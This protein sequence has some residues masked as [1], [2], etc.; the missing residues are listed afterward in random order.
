MVKKLLFLGIAS[1]FFLM[2]GCTS[3]TNSTASIIIIDGKEYY[4]QDIVATN[5]YTID[6]EVGEIKL[7]VDSDTVPTKNFS[8]NTVKVGTKIYSVKEN[9]NIYLIKV[10]SNKHQIFTH[11][12]NDK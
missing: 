3:S 6:K 4:G 1:V 11:K 5:K 9:Q 2:S 10:N 7:L 8:S 12:A